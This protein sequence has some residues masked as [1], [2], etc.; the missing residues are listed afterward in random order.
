MNKATFPALATI[1]LA[2]QARGDLFLHYN[3]NICPG[4]HE[5]EIFLDDLTG[6][7]PGRGYATFGAGSLTHPSSPGSSGNRINDYATLGTRDLSTEFNQEWYASFMWRSNYGEAA[8]VSFR[9]DDGGN[10]N[11]FIVSAFVDGFEVL[12]NNQRQYG[13]PHDMGINVTNFILMHYK[14]LPDGSSQLE[15][16]LNP[17]PGNLPAASLRAEF[18]SAFPMNTMYFVNWAGGGEMDELR[19]GSE[20]SDVAN[21]P[22]PSTTLALLVMLAAARKRQ[23]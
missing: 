12:Y 13:T 9:F 14:P 3:F 4:H 17:D 19:F 15:L 8:G 21:I 11:K 16:W 10:I 20:I 22:A 2:A 1:I 6:R 5:E 7:N 18:S 23:R